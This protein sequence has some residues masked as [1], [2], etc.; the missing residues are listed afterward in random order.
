MTKLIIIRHCETVLNAQG[1]IQ[2]VHTDSAFTPE[3]ERQLSCILSRFKLEQIHAIYCS[4]LGR[5][6]R[7]AEA[8]AEDHHLQPLIVESL[9]E[10]DIGEWKYLPLKEA[11]HKWSLFYENMKKKGMKREEIRPPHGEN[12]FD[13]QKRVMSVINMILK[14]HPQESVVIVGHSGTNKVIIG[15]LFGKDPDDFYSLQ[16]SN[17]CV[18]ILEIQNG[19]VK[20]ICLNDMSHLMN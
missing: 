12:S 4:D 10:C 16:Q 3:G 2:S 18:N 19:K 9:K 8:I 14:K 6:F 15:S 7:T 20:E 1:K 17:A 5:S 13:H 11:L